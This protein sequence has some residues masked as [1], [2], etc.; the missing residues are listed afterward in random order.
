MIP[1]YLG[2]GVTD[3]EEIHYGIRTENDYEI[4]PEIEVTLQTPS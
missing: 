4:Y 3:N 1:F 2:V